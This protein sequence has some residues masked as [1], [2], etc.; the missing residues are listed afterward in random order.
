MHCCLNVLQGVTLTDLKEAERSSQAR[1]I[2]DGESVDGRFCVRKCVTDD[3]GVKETER[4]EAVET[5]ISWR[6][7]DEVSEEVNAG[8]SS[9]LW[10]HKKTI[11]D[12]SVNFACLTQQ[13]NFESLLESLPESPVPNLSFSSGSTGLP[14]GNNSPRGQKSNTK[15]SF[16]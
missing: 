1:L 7:T 9:A 6:Q 12:S 13:E 11:C 5:S 10:L 4:M 8:S 15:N 3:G 14:Q 2:K 16:F